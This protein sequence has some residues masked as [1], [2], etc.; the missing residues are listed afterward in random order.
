MT[1]HSWFATPVPRISTP[2]T[3]KRRKSSGSWSVASLQVRRGGRRVYTTRVHFRAPER[4]S[5]SRCRNRFTRS[6]KGPVST[7]CRKI[8]DFLVDPFLH[9]PL[10]SQAIEP[11]LTLLAHAA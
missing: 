5:I 11:L 4:A 9:F 1:L 3:G 6:Q 2:S 8:F 10:E 7:W